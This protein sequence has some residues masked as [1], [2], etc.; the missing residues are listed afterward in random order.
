MNPTAS[1]NPLQITL[2]I[3]TL[4][5]ILGV[6]ALVLY[7]VISYIRLKRRVY[8]AT[9]VQGNIYST[10]KIQT[11]FVLGFIRPK[12]YIPTSIGG[13]QLSHILKHEQVHVRRRD[14]LIKPLAF[15]VLAVH[16]FN[17]VVWACYFLLSKDMETSCDEAVLRK[18]S[19]DIRRDYSACLVNLYTRKPRLLS[20]LAF[21]E[22]SYRNMKSRINNVLKFKKP[23]RW[24]VIACLLLVAVLL[25]GCTTNPPK[26]LV[27]EDLAVNQPVNN[28]QANTQVAGPGASAS[29]QVPIAEAATTMQSVTY[30]KVWMARPP[31]DPDFPDG[32]HPRPHPHIQW[33][34]TNGTYRAI[35]TIQRGMLAFDKDGQ[36]LKIHWNIFTDDENAF[37]YLPGDDEYG[38]MGLRPQVKSSFARIDEYL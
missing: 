19:D 34:V 20:P 30:E 35:H 18:S 22:G 29:P 31:I 3:A 1:A 24:T 25:V 5:W 21:G 12:I 6:A 28:A 14:Y 32:V 38:A 10:D 16:W 15:L 7:A 11:A 13:A 9:L 26:P 33:S 23:S 4:V 27:P 2:S 17:P 36:P 37:F 8:D